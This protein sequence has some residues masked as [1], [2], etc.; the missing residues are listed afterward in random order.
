M[1]L[2]SGLKIGSGNSQLNDIH[3]AVI[4]CFHNCPRECLQTCFNSMDVKECCFWMQKYVR[5]NL[6]GSC[7]RTYNSLTCMFYF[8]VKILMKPRSKILSS[9]YR[10]NQFTGNY[11]ADYWYSKIF[12][13]SNCRRKVIDSNFR[14][15]ASQGEYRHIRTVIMMI[16][17]SCWLSGLVNMAQNLKQVYSFL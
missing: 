3:S 13:W 11:A 7:N 12:S 8:S 17:I 16:L 15:W 14:F 2:I 9:S 10:M 6:N 4:D 1:F 5:R